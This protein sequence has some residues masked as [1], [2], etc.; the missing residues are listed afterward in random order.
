MGMQDAPLACPQPLNPSH[1]ADLR[2]AASHMTGAKR[3]AFEAEMT[4]Q[5]CGGTPLLAETIFGWGRRTVAV[6][7]AERRT[8]LT[9]LGAQSACSG[10]TRWEEQDPEAAEALGRLA[11][12]PAQYD[13]TCRTTLASTRLTANAALEALRAPGEEKEPWPSPSTMAE[14]LNRLGFR[15]RQVVKATPQKK[16][17]E[18][19]AMC[20]NSEKTPRRQ[21]P[22]QPSNACVSM[23]KPRWRSVRSPAAASRGAIT[24]HVS[25]TWACLSNIVPVGSWL[26]TVRRCVSPLAAL[27]R[28]VI[29]SSMRSRPGGQRW[30]R[31][32]RWPWR[33]CRAQ[34]RTAR[35]AVGDGRHVCS[36]GWRCAMALASR[37]LCC[38][39]HPT[40]GSRIPSSAV[41]ASWNGTGTGRSWWMERRCWSGRKG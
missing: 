10:R 25:T 3:R 29:A 35:R 4:M 15:L 19:D 34:W 1:I 31:P 2:L 11:E 6:G 38:T 33:G 26:Q 40:R 32:S 9:C 41:G 37:F 16:M 12:A 39:P 21:R 8:G 13:P 17:A 24:G 30:M 27:A 7:R 28:P 23:V 5:Y 22:R 20:A 14:V 18:T 36:G